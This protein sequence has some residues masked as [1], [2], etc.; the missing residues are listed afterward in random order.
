MSEKSNTYYTDKLKKFYFNDWIITVLIALWILVVPAIAGIAL[1]IL[2]TIYTSKSKIEYQKILEQASK[3]DELAQTVSDQ[4]EKI[5]S[6]EPLLSEDAKD[7]AKLNDKKMA[8]NKEIK[9]L[10]SILNNKKDEQ[11]NIEDQLSAIKEK[12]KEKESKLL[13]LDDDILV[14]DFGIYKP[15]FDFANSSKYKDKLTEIRNQQKACIKN[16][17][18]ATGSKDWSVNG[19]KRKGSKMVS[20]MQK[21]LIRAFNSECD[22]L[23]NKVKY[24]N[25]DAILKRM[26]SSRDAI[27]KLGTIM[28]VAITDK[29]FNLKVEELHLALEYAIVKNDEKEAAREARAQQREAER[30]E[31]EIAEQRKKAEKEQEHYQNALDSILK[32]IKENA[33]PSQDLLDKKA[34]LEAQLGKIDKAMKDLDYREANQRAGYVYVIS[35]IGAFGEDVYKIGMTR[36]LNPQERVDELGDASVPFNFDVH[37]MIFSDDAPALENALHKA[38]ENKKVN[39]VNQRREF[40]HVTLDEIKKVINDNFDKTVEF[41][42]VPDAEQYRITQTMLSH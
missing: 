2:K 34:E 21:L 18:A 6:M 37:A 4:K 27:S 3:Y 24:N 1:L 7:V 39:M 32:Q 35:N 28:N 9:N 22:E 26:T 36:R 5:E 23:V 41:K 20:D 14:Q 40:F 31:R 12:I 25:F 42:D 19:D 29:Y 17:S 10:D 38:F 13:T 15:L 11:K 8:L 30:L 33:E 16:K